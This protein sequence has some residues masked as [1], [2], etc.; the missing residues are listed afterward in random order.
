[1]GGRSDAAVR[2]LP[3]SQECQNTWMEDRARR[4]PDTGEGL[5][6]NRSESCEP[7]GL[8]LR[9]Q[10]NEPSFLNLIIYLYSSVFFLG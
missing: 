10:S 1:M 5:R 3:E 6:E 4:T 8:F 2:V 7:I 9:Q